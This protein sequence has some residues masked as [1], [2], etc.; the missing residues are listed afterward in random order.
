[1]IHQHVH[2][3]TQIPFNYHVRPA[4]S[5][6]L[7]APQ[8]TVTALQQSPDNTAKYHMHAKHT[9]HPAMNY[10]SS[11]SVTVGGDSF[12][13]VPSLVCRGRVMLLAAFACCAVSI[14]IPPT[15]AA[16]AVV[17]AL[18]FT[19]HRTT[20]K[21]YLT[22]VAYSTWHPSMPF[23]LL[24]FYHAAHW[25]PHTLEQSCQSMISDI[26]TN[27]LIPPRLASSKSSQQH[28]SSH[29]LPIKRA[30]VQC[31]HQHAMDDT[32]LV[33]THTRY[34]K[35]QQTYHVV[36]HVVQHVLLFCTMLDATHQVQT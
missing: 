30:L 26:Q 33:N 5:T 35:Q 24:H 8:P 18:P 2:H 3:S 21:I 22:P 25:P 15:I 29:P 27:H 10:M 6:C 7:P 23:V 12:A 28:H 14:Y 11:V 9:S 4:Q 32:P 13:C 36:E 1:M 20:C 34:A 17:Y 31:R 16:H 19:L